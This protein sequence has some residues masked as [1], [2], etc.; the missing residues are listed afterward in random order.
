MEGSGDPELKMFDTKAEP[1]F[2]LRSVE[3]KRFLK[4][5]SACFWHYNGDVVTKFI[6]CNKDLSPFQI[7]YLNILV[8]DEAIALKQ[9]YT[10]KL[11]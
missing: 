8:S 9:S 10:L 7:L 2:Q 1:H 4:I 5:T 3:I 11:H 6:D